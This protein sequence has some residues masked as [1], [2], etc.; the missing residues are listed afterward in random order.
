M[1]KSCSL[2][3]PLSV[4]NDYERVPGMICSRR[5]NWPIEAGAM[6]NVTC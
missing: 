4:E 5:V 3:L 6:V 2:I 1:K